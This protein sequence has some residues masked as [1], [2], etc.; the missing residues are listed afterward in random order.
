MLDIQYDAPFDGRLVGL[1]K[2]TR[3]GDAY[4]LTQFEPMY[5]R[6]AFPSFDEPAFKAP[7]DVWLK[8]PADQMAVSNMPELGSWPLPDELKLVHFAPTPPLPTYADRVCGWP[9][10]RCPCTG[11]SSE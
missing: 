5:A 7:F 4:T 6:L 1:Y 10:R 3:G 8:V 11:N 9:F 2:V